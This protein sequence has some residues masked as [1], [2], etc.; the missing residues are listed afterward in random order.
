MSAS[1]LV[2]DDEREIQD[3][4]AW[5]LR[6]DGHDVLTARDGKQA[7]ALLADRRFDLGE[8]HDELSRLA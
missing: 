6:N 7:T 1:I 8:P 2:V 3:A 5:W 4:V